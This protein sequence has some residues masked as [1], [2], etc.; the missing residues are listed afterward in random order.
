MEIKDLHGVLVVGCS[1]AFRLG[2][3]STGC[4][5]RD[6]VKSTEKNYPSDKEE[7]YMDSMNDIYPLRTLE[8]GHCLCLLA[9]LYQNNHR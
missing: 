3:H 7:N 1:V 5:A 6:S 4:Q 2:L 9:E 8:W